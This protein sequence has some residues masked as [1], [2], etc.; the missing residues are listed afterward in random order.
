MEHR[1]G[2]IEKGFEDG[3]ISY[4][5]A[6]HQKMTEVR[7]GKVQG[8]ENDIPEQAIVLGEEKSDLVVVGWGSTFGP[9][10][11]AVIRMRAEGLNVSHVH[12]RYL[13]PFPKNLENLLKG[14]KKVLVPEMNMGQLSTVLKDRFLLDLVQL[15]KVSG[16]PFKIRDIMSAIKENLN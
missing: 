10:Y 8:I 3:H 9:I 16:Q 7:A 2:G 11:Q 13:N 4:D 5:P 14:Y 1:I 6:N 15:N 12:I